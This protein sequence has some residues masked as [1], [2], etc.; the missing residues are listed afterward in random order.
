MEKFH[1]ISCLLICATIL[2]SVSN[3]QKLRGVIVL[4]RAGLM[5]VYEHENVANGSSKYSLLV[6]T[7]DPRPNSVD[8]AYVLDRPGRFINN[9]ITV[10]PIPLDHLFS[11]PKE[12]QQLD[13]AAF[14]MDAV[15]IPDGASISGK[16]DGHIYIANVTDF[17]NVITYDI[18]SPRTPNLKVTHHYTDAIFKRMSLIGGKD[19]LT[20]RAV[21]VSGLYNGSELVHLKRPDI[22]NDLL[23][24]WK[25]TVL[26]EKACDANLVE[27]P[28][29]ETVL[30]KWDVIYAAGSKIKQLSIIW[31]ETKNG[32]QGNWDDPTHI[33]MLK[34]DQGR[35]VTDVQAVDINGDLKLDIIASIEGKNGSV[36]IWELPS[37]D[38]RLVSNYTK[39]VLDT[40]SSL[41]GG[42]YQGLTPGAVSVHHPT[43]K[44]IGKPWIFVAGA[45]NNMVHYYVP[46]SRDPKDWRYAKNV[47]VDL[48]RGMTAGG[49][50]VVDLDGDG[51]MEVVV[52]CHDLY[53]LRVYSLG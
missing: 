47:L 44:K 23:R 14:G 27:I 35:A 25:D 43:S 31:A 42:I 7:Y 36:E 53:E 24:P 17:K 5:S 51:S 40:Y 10:K 3:A 12:M 39:H 50:A 33:K 16:S 13:G 15:L 11:W 45:D 34:L 2:L 1:L 41:R 19:I 49:L 38:F 6:S 21:Y 22:G 52:S 46:L 29:F 32:T 8:Y 37:K 4:H 26:K 30:K 18:T 28:F 9:L 48:G 20:C